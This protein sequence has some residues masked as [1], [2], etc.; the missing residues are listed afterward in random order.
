MQLFWRL[1]IAS[2]QTDAFEA[3][4]LQEE[5]GVL[6]QGGPWDVND[7]VL[8]STFV[9]FTHGNAPHLGL[10]DIPYHLRSNF[11][12][13]QTIETEGGFGPKV[14]LPQGKSEKKPILK[15]WISDKKS[16]Q[17]EFFLSEIEMS[18]KM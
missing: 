12:H 14:K 9:E 3:V 5:S 10:L 13:L 1:H 16:V 7:H 8:T 4:F 15:K 2:E 6:V 18:T 17:K 11:D